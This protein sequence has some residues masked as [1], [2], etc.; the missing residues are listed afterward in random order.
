M[1]YKT[2][3]APLP[4]ELIEQIQEYVDGRVIY[5]PKKQEHKKH[6]GTDTDTKTFLSIRNYEICEYYRQGMSIKELSERYYLTE[7]SIRRILKHYD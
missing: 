4:E 5:I 2:Q 6:W 7:K 3:T 1:S